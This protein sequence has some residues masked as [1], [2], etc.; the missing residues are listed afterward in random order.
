MQDPVY[1]FRYRPF[2]P[3]IANDSCYPLDNTYSCQ[4]VYDLQF[5]HTYSISDLSRPQGLVDPALET[6]PGQGEAT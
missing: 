3:V 2:L 6:C 1:R 5:S 4:D